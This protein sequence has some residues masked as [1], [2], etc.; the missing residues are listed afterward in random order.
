MLHCTPQYGAKRNG[1]AGILRLENYGIELNMA[2]CVAKP[3][4]SNGLA[5]GQA[6][7]F[8][9]LFPT[10]YDFDP[11]SE[12]RKMRDCCCVTV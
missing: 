9:K 1:G 5:A 11:R 10:T 4:E 6:S 3:L 7:P 8:W 12:T 2:R